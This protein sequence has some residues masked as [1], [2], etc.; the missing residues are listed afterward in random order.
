MKI[1]Y[2]LIML[3]MI[4]L[5]I[6]SCESYLGDGINENPN[7]PTD[8]PVSVILPNALVNA[9]DLTGGF[10]SRSSAVLTQQVEGVARQWSSINNYSSFNPA[11]ANTGWNNTYEN[12]L[13]EF[14]TMKDKAVE[15]GFTHYE[16]VA[17]IMIAYV[18][19][20]ATDVWDRIPYSDAL[21][22]TEVLKPSFDEQSAIYTEVFSLLSSGRTLLAGDDGGSAPGGDDVIYGG[23]T[24]KWVKAS[25]AIEARALLHQGKYA[26]ALT[27]VGSSFESAADNLAYQ[28]PGG[29]AGAAQW[30]RFNRD[31]TGDIEFHPTM[32]KIMDD[33]GDKWR[34][35]V[36][37]QTFITDHTYLIAAFNQEMV[38]YR[39]L[40]FIEAEALSRGSG[41][42]TGAFQEGIEASFARLGVDG[43]AAYI[44]ANYSGVPT[45]EQIMTE[46]YIAL[47]LQPEAYSDFRRTGFPALTPTSGSVIPVR[48]PYGEDETI[49]NE[50]NVPKVD[51]FTDKVG[52]NK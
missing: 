10:F 14:I 28:Y 7:S 25:F 44:A 43:D 1:S 12:T 40:K 16:G 26:E 2:K 50:E 51:I 24:D 9:A 36:F 19:L 3:S 4:A 37:D 20:Q 27:A 48:F 39:E 35:P 31:R 15:R 21:K 30:Y 5:I 34:E 13:I 11:Y 47:F 23:D 18:L 41:D 17:N 6:S 29:D 33:L 42:P 52:W 8:A 45:L 22:G 32:E 46:K 49:F 38:T